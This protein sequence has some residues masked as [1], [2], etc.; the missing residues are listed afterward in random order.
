L[1]QIERRI[2]GLTQPCAERWRPCILSIDAHQ[3]S[4]RGHPGK[5]LV[6]HACCRRMKEQHAATARCQDVQDVGH[7]S[8]HVQVGP[9]TSRTQAAQ[10][11]E[12]G[13]RC[14]RAKYR[15]LVARG[16]S[17]GAQAPR[18]AIAQRKRLRLGEIASLPCESQAFRMGAIAAK[19]QI[20]D[21]HG[22]VS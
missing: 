18:D 15:E 4:Q 10:H 17:A 14:V 9:G 7:C 20:S 12:H 2:V 3:L 16:E 13:Q 22:D 11:G 6:D 8:P 21:V 5:D 19:E 1:A